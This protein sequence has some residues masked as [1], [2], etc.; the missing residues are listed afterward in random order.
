MP[1]LASRLIE[2][3]NADL[4]TASDFLASWPP[5]DSSIESFIKSLRSDF[6]DA[7][8]FAAQS[9][10]LRRMYHYPHLMPLDENQLYR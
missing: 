5:T 2:A 9:A 10:A 4:K 3:A 7:Y 1:H 8:K 6:H